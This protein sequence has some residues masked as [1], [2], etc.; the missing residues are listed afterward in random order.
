MDELL[1]H[2]QYYF[3]NKY[4]V[5]YVNIL[6]LEEEKF[7]SNFLC[8]CLMPSINNLKKNVFADNK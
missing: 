5:L 7:I 8:I 6:Q 3:S 2:R 4:K 1:L